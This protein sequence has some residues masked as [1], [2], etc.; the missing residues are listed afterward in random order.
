MKKSIL[1]DKIDDLDQDYINI[2]EVIS[3]FEIRYFLDKLKLIV[4][5]IFEVEDIS[6]KCKK[7]QYCVARSV[8]AYIALKE[9][10]KKTQIA[11]KINK[12]RTT[13]HHMV[14][15]FKDYQKYYPQY[16]TKINETLNWYDDN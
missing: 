12:D 1:I 16:K 10:Y 11:Q 4:E 13:V 9:K 8:F 7:E 5:N 2:K 15:K 6:N 3:L 14:V